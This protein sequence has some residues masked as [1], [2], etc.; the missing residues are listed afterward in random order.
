MKETIF[1][2]I[3]SYRDKLCSHTIESLID[4]AKYPDR[5]TVGICEQNEDNDASCIK[6]KYKPY[7]RIIR[8]KSDEAEG[9]GYA[10]FLCSQLF[11][12][13][14]YFFQI[15]SHCK[16]VNNWDL[17]I[18][19]MIKDCDSSKPILSHY[20]KD[21]AD[22]NEDPPD[23]TQVTYIPKAFIN[24]R[25]LISFT[26]AAFMNAPK[27][28]KKNYFIA[29]GFVFAPS[30]FIKEVPFDPYLPYLF[31]GEEILL[32]A[33][34]FTHGWDVFS[35]NKDILYHFY[36]R[37]DEP[38]FWE[39][40]YKQPTD[41]ELKV[42]IILGQADTSEIKNIHN[43]MIR[44]SI[45]KY[46]IGTKRSLKEFYQKI[47]IKNKI[48]VREQNTTPIFWYVMII[49]FCIFSMMCFFFIVK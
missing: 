28:P 4:H 19:R 24:D 7:I 34:A 43:P 31:V 48:N 3:A 41:A 27:K 29:A 11:E 6:E 46:T 25:G 45:K 1:V 23:N 38:K 39:K 22:Y 30:R 47:S 8:M 16:F 18:I 10:R 32:S 40:N 17:K 5:I 33:R 49:L 13:Q 35:P 44:E 15:D 12:N 2:S 42:K 9:P 36:T 14:D 21:F 26:G 37:K 20:P